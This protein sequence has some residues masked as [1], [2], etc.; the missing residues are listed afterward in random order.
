DKD[1]SHV[2]ALHRMNLRASDWSDL[3]FA[4]KPDDKSTVAVSIYA[5]HFMVNNKLARRLDRLTADDGFFVGNFYLCP[6]EQ[7]DCAERE[8][9]KSIL[10]R[11]NMTYFVIDDPAS[12]AN[13]YWIIASQQNAEQAG[14]YARTLK[15]AIAVQTPH[16]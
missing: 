3:Q 5:L 10:D 13:E 1:P 16:R 11:H 4:D 6:A 9:L 12:N 2:H 15:A 14:A 7:K 8:R